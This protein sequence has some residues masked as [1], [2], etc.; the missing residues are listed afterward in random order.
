[1][2]EEGCGREGGGRFGGRE[3]MAAR[4]TGEERGVR[5]RRGGAA[6]GGGGG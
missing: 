1:M 4:D 6:S 5:W 2:G 3:R